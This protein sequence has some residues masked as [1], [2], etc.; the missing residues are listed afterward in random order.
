[1]F[2]SPLKT[3]SEKI[4]PV[5]SKSSV[6]SLKFERPSDFKK[7]INFIK[8]ETKELEKIKLPKTAEV[9]SKSKR[10]GVLGLLGLGLLGL[11]GSGFG[12]GDGKDRFSIAGGTKSQFE[13]LIPG[14]PIG[15]VANLRQAK[16]GQINLRKSLIEAR[17]KRF[18]RPTSGEKKAGEKL[19]KKKLSKTY[20]TIRQQK[21]V[22]RT[23]KKFA[24]LEYENLLKKQKQI[25]VNSAKKDFDQLQNTKRGKRFAKKFAPGL[26]DSIEKMINESPAEKLSRI[27]KEIQNVRDPKVKAQLQNQMDNLYYSPAEMEQQLGRYTQEDFERAEKLQ[28]KGEEKLKKEAELEKKYEEQLKKE[29]KKRFKKRYAFRGAPKTYNIDFNLFGKNVKFTPRDFLSGKFK[30]FGTAT[31]PARD[32]FTNTISKIPGS[33]ATFGVGKSLLKGL[34]KRYDIITTLYEGFQLVKGFV[35]KDNIFTSYYDLGV[36]IHNMF[37]PDKAKL[38][39]YITNH[40]DSRLKVKYQQK[41]QKILQEIQKAKEAQALSGGF[42]PINKASDIVPFAVQKTGQQIMLSSPAFTGYRFILDKLYKQ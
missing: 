29:R 42:N 17:K 36:R 37:Q 6:S 27:A 21:R 30:Q 20:E 41:N 12:D 22:Q 31:K 5:E 8:N 2:Q 11:L 40:Q 1:M 32:M 33:K 24:R 13:K 10:G 23:K 26:D 39:T 38:M 16:V 28:K 3:V 7:F 18:Q 34:G 35:V 4:K 15:G 9:E 14:V 19:E 25:Q